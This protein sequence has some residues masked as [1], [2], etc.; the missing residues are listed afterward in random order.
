MNPVLEYPFLLLSCCDLSLA[1]L[2]QLEI[3]SAGQ[4]EVQ[5]WGQLFWGIYVGT[6]SKR[7]WVEKFS[8][9]DK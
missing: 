2:C 3:F 4:L 1:S 5:T 8:K 7:F 9:P 6:E